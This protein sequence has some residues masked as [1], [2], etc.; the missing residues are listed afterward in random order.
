MANF[1]EIKTNVGNRVGDTSTTFATIIGRYINNRYRDV[2]RRMNFNSI[3]PDFKITA[4]SASTYTS[5]ATYTLPS[6]FGKEQFVYNT[7]TD[8]EIPYIGLEK[9]VQEYYDEYEN[10]GTI[11]YYSIY[12]TKNTTASSAEA[13]AARCKKIQ[14]WRAPTTD[15]YFL[16]PYTIRPADLSSSADECVIACEAALEYGAAADAWAYKR[17]FAKAGYYEQLYEKEIQS[18][19]WDEVNQQNVTHQMNV[20]PLS[21]D[22]GI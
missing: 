16:I 18:L 9:L 20:T 22:E 14:F 11:E 1:S 5:A 17:Q 3:C 10:T 21:R 19:I 2:L 12:D 4:T 6:D 13:T 8:E 15:N 7:G